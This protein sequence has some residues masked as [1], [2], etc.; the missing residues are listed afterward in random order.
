MIPTEHALAGL[1]HTM[2]CQAGWKFD[3][4]KNP[5][6]AGGNWWCCLP[7]GQKLLE[8]AYPKHY[9]TAG[10]TQIMDAPKRSY[11]LAICQYLNRQCAHGG[12]WIVA[13]L[14]NCR[15]FFMVWKDADGDFQVPIECDLSWEQ[16]QTWSLDNWA[17]HAEQAYRAWK[18]HVYT[19]ALH[20]NQLVKAAQGER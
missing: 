16:I 1:S 19:L 11:A 14:D 17:E 3:A 8:F 9:L 15:Q 5:Y 13:W 12:C 4:D 6:Q 2:F 7:S 10:A 18:E 20:K